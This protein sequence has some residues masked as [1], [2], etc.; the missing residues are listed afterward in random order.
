MQMAHWPGV[1]QVSCEP[2]PLL[3]EGTCCPLDASRCFGLGCYQHGTQ[4]AGALDARS[5]EEVAA[6]EAALAGLIQRAERIERARSIKRQACP[7]P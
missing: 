7:R 4:A 5:E 2:P 6:A 3:H 1:L